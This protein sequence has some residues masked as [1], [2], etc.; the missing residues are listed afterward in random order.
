MIYDKC[1]NSKHQGSV[2]ETRA[3]YE[4]TKLGYIVSKPMMDCDYDLLVDDGSVIKKVQ[5]KTTKTIKRGNYVCNLRVMGGNQTF[6]T[7]KHRTPESWDILFVV[8]CEGECWSIPA[9]EFKAT[10]LLTIDSR[11]DRFKV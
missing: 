4:Y 7:V 11:F 9:T 6:T 1:K 5:V 3:I 10:N 8:G 2:G